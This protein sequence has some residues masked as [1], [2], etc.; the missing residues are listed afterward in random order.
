MHDDYFNGRINLVRTGAGGS[1]AA[2]RSS[3]KRHEYRNKA[4]RAVN[5]LEYGWQR[6]R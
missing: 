1:Q 5:S 3:V 6:H 2:T 4:G